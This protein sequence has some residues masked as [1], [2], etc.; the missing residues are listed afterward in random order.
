MTGTSSP[1]GPASETNGLVRS[2]MRT[3]HSRPVGRRRRSD[4]ETLRF[5]LGPSCGQT[6]RHGPIKTAPSAARPRGLSSGSADGELRATSGPRPPRSASPVRARS[7]SHQLGV[8]PGARERSRRVP[9]AAGGRSRLPGRVKDGPWRPRPPLAGP[10]HFLPPRGRHAPSTTDGVL[11]TLRVKYRAE[12]RGTQD[13]SSENLT[14]SVL[15]MTLFAL[16]SA[17]PL[18]MEKSV[19]QSRGSRPHRGCSTHGWREPAV[20]R[21]FLGESLSASSSTVQRSPL[22]IF[23]ANAHDCTR[24]TMPPCTKNASPV[25]GHSAVAR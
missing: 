18:Q 25:N 11:T 22:S 6:G 12:I 9:G 8:E 14:E 1:P 24:R 19:T 5:A 4:Y 17:S 15:F 21:Y 23:S 3:T 20:P 16:R 2:G 10:A 13:T 7:H